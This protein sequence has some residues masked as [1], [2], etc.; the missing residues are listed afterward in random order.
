MKIAVTNTVL[1]NAG[2]AAIYQSI[3]EACS[4]RASDDIVVTALDGAAPTTVDLYP[5]WNIEQQMSRSASRPAPIRRLSNAL[6]GAALELLIR[7]SALRRFALEGP[8]RDSEFSKALRVISDADVVV[9]SG[10]TYLVDHYRFG[11]R[12]RELLVARAMGKPIVLWTQSMGPFID[13]AAARALRRLAP[14]VDAVYFRDDRSRDAWERVAPL[15]AVHAVLPDTVFGMTLERQARPSD[16]SRTAYLSVRNWAQAVEGGSLDYAQYEAG[17]R[18]VAETLTAAGWNCIALSTCQGVP[19][20]AVDDAAT[21]R[22]IFAGL[23]VTIDEDF[24]TPAEL[25]EMIRSADLVVATRMHFAILSLLAGTPVVAIAYETKTIDLFGTLGASAFVTPIEQVDG[26]W[27]ARVGADAIGATVD[28][29]R[30]EYV[31]A[32]A[33]SPADFVHSLIR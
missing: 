26:P 31:R 28:D 21:A 33:S 12:V 32:G 15:P 29:E 25:F 22:R 20:Y 18:A 11:H 8:V 13:A 14:H 24:H 19:G 2:D 1:S 7:S 16:G 9:S 27:G 10:G 23:P 3:L 30:L 17:M 5:E 4:A 6:R